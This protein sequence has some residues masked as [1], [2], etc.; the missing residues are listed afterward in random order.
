MEISVQGPMDLEG[1]SQVFLE[2]A[3]RKRHRSWNEEQITKFNEE[4]M[5]ERLR[6]IE[7]NSLRTKKLVSSNQDFLY[8][9]QQLKLTVEELVS[10]INDP[11]HSKN[12]VQFFT[13]QFGILRRQFHNLNSNFMLHFYWVKDFAKE[14]QKYQ[15]FQPPNFDEVVNIQKFH[16]SIDELLHLL[17]HPSIDTLA[18]HHYCT[19]LFSTILLWLSQISNWKSEEEAVIQRISSLREGDY[20]T[21]YQYLFK[22]GKAAHLSCDSI[23]K[24]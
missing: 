22:K 8:Q 6:L 21:F 15:L 24:Y 23:A 3:G 10:E 20:L 1:V 2:D 13:P 16:H 19:S 12:Y 11:N 4:E 5:K 9:M 7:K 18:K 14:L 17:C